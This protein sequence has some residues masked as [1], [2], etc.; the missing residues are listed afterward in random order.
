VKRGSVHW[1]VLGEVCCSCLSH[2]PRA[3][4]TICVLAS[5][6]S[7]LNHTDGHLGP[8][9]TR[10]AKY[11]DHA[12]CCSR[13]EPATSEVGGHSAGSLAASG[14]ALRALLVQLWSC[15]RADSS[16]SLT[17]MAGQ[18]CASLV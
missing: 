9:T 1:L 11:R 14:P 3:R 18:R 8:C 5:C 4:V 6:T 7:G 17:P 15:S 10:L 16:A 13:H 12:R 2:L